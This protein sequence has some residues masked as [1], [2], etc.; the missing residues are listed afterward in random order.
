M[1]GD[2]IVGVVA[3]DK[4]AGAASWGWS[5]SGLDEPAAT[6]PGTP[7]AP[8]SGA[9]GRRR[10]QQV[11]PGGTDMPRNKG[12]S[13]TESGMRGHKG[14]NRDTKQEQAEH[15]REQRDEDDKHKFVDQTGLAAQDRPDKGRDAPSLSDANE[16]TRNLPQQHGG[17]VATD[18]TAEGG[19]RGDRQISDADDHGGRKHN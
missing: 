14:S 1:W 5:C 8:H 6:I 13:R 15:A 4:P 17:E 10:L 12:P 9:G 16:L 3:E 7:L 19:L 11:R 2:M 18:P